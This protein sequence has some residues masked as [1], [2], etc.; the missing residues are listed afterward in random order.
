VAELRA[1]NT[2]MT[3]LLKKSDR[4]DDGSEADVRTPTYGLIP[5]T[6]RRRLHLDRQEDPEPSGRSAATK[7][8]TLF[9]YVGKDKDNDRSRA[10]Q[11][12]YKARPTPDGVCCSR[13]SRDLKTTRRRRTSGRA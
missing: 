9:K 8:S 5:T 2:A 11:L 3:H 4:T 7:S 6:P 13:S 1:N 10:R 12:V